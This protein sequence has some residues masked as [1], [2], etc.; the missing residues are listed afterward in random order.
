MSNVQI[1]PSTGLPMPQAPAPIS[2]DIAGVPSEF[3]V[4]REHYVFTLPEEVLP[5]SWKREPKDRTFALTLLSVAEEESAMRSMMANGGTP[6]PAAVSK[7]WFL[8][9]VYAIGGAYTRRNFDTI[10]Q[11]M[12]DIGPKGRKLLD[13]AHTHLHNVTPKQGEDFLATMQR[14][15]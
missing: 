3:I 7:A 8:A 5:A 9:S 12:E 15:G 1:D 11:W 6:D 13:Q 14:R 4:Q 10:T 2:A